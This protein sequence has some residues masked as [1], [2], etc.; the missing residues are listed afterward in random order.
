MASSSRAAA[1]RV[2]AFTPVRRI[3]QLLGVTNLFV[4]V[5]HYGVGQD[6]VCMVWIIGLWSVNYLPTTASGVFSGNDEPTI[7]SDL[8]VY[9]AA[10]CYTVAKRRHLFRFCEIKPVNG[11]RHFSPRFEECTE[12]HC[13]TSSLV[14][15]FA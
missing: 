3:R 9:T 1:G 8:T 7:K 14:C 10:N 13:P 6:N 11:E 12:G 5:L 4:A 15:L 2:W